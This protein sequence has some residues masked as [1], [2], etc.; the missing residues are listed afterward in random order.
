MCDSQCCPELAQLCVDASFFV[1]S[2]ESDCV[3]YLYLGI[4]YL[5][6]ANRCLFLTSTQVTKDF[7]LTIGPNKKSIATVSVN[8]NI[9]ST[10]HTITMDEPTI[11]GKNL[12][13]SGGDVNTDDIIYSCNDGFSNGMLTFENLFT[14]EKVSNFE[15]NKPTYD[16]KLNGV[17][18]YQ[19]NF[20][21]LYEELRDTVPTEWDCCKYCIVNTPSIVLSS[22]I[23]DGIYQSSKVEQYVASLDNVTAIDEDQAINIANAALCLQLR[24]NKNVLNAEATIADSVSFPPGDYDVCVSYKD[25][26]GNFQNLHIFRITINQNDTIV[27]KWGRHTTKSGLVIASPKDSAKLKAVEGSTKVNITVCGSLE[28]VFNNTN[29]FVLCVENIVQLFPLFD[30]EG[31]ITSSEGVKPWADVEFNVEH[32]SYPFL[33]ATLANTK[34]YLAIKYVCVVPDETSQET[35]KPHQMCKGQLNPFDNSKSTAAPGFTFIRGYTIAEITNMMDHPLLG[36]HLSREVTLCISSN[37]IATSDA[38]QA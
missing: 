2:V 13:V 23:E 32:E 6:L 20:T 38:C 8:F 16:V 14:I 31:L 1:P 18:L 35:S 15:T 24:A 27:G 19:F 4:Y 29:D 34:L 9:D 30:T 10:N 28:G 7:D 21:D 37:D 11:E 12:H 26:E 25:C 36:S 33:Y 22:S 17:K 3:Y 5:D